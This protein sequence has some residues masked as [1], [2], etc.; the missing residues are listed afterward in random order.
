MHP[1]CTDSSHSHWRQRW[2]PVRHFWITDAFCECRDAGN[3]SGSISHRTMFPRDL[4]ITPL[5]DKWTDGYICC[6]FSYWLHDYLYNI[7]GSY[8]LISLWIYLNYSC[9]KYR[10]LILLLHHECILSYIY[11]YLLNPP[12]DFQ[13]TLYLL[14]LYWFVKH[15]P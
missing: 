13:Y 8:N 3:V 11:H 5:E 7:L 15:F 6:D 9:C 12:L 14:Y 1:H 10:L 2:N 4:T